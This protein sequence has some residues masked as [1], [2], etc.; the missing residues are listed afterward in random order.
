[1]K[2]LNGSKI[3]LIVSFI[4]LSSTI[5]RAQDTS[6]IYFVTAAGSLFPVSSFSNAYKN[7]L[8]LNSGIEF[9]ISKHYFT[10][11]VLDFN[12][13]NYDQQI[14]DGTSP[15]LFQHTSS[16]V[17]LAGLNF[18]RNISITKSGKL[19]VSPYFG[20]GYA[21][22]GEPRLTVNNSTGIIEQAVSRMTG[23][24][25]REGLRLGYQTRSKVLQTIY[26]DVSRWSANITVQ[27]SRPRAFT[28]LIG[29]RF[30]F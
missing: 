8:A 20:L 10:Q 15:Y 1:M 30:G 25:L 28:V 13:I 5:V 2:K 11:F 22:I 18:G 3:L 23:I 16:S 6:K 29:T 9:K 19:F 4:I 27:D 14:K 17:F 24:Y 21:N 7:S 26:V 12:A